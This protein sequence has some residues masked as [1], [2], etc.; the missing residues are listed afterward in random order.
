MVR[1][2][3]N[4]FGIG[5]AMPRRFLSLM[6]VIA[7]SLSSAI[8]AQPAI[9]GPLSCA[10]GGECQVGDIGPGGGV[11]FFVKGSGAFHREFTRSV[12]IDDMVRS[13]IMENQ[14]MSVD[15]TAPQQEAISF[16]YLEAAPASG[17]GQTRWASTTDGMPTGSQLIGSGIASSNHII[18]ATASDT[19]G[20]NAAHYAAA[21]SHN[22]LSDWFLPSRDELALLTIEH[23]AG[24]LGSGDPIGSIFYGWTTTNVNDGAIVRI[25]SRTWAKNYTVT[26]YGTADVLP[27]RAIS[28]STGSGPEVQNTSGPSI[29]THSKVKKV[30]FTKTE[31]ILSSAMKNKLKKAVRG[32]IEDA[33]IVVTGVVG[34]IDGTSRNDATK[35]GKNRAHAIRSYLVKLGV[36]RS[37]ISIKTKIV[38]PQVQP[39]S[40]VV[41]KY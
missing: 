32:H 7:V 15:L 23:V 34:R 20:N 3:G 4:W 25:D 22:G 40:T 36:K 27:I 19:A 28:R 30:N 18:S 8:V 31:S 6:A 26:I 29:R 12:N 5:F 35:L 37:Q 16:D 9:A 14:T 33:T 41:I 17:M 11:I 1:A 39:M 10:D 21:Y 2:R 38:G 24:T 13:V